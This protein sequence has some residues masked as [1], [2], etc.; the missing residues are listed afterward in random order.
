M[1]V[2]IFVCLSASPSRYLSVVSH[3]SSSTYRPM[4][5]LSTSLAAPRFLLEG[6]ILVHKASLRRH[7]D[8]DHDRVNTSSVV[9][10]RSYQSFS[11]TS[12]SFYFFSC[13]SNSTIRHNLA[14]T[15][16]GGAIYLEGGSAFSIGT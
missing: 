10:R 4:A 13:N 6:M 5:Q 11:P 9:Y 14:T 16:G 12:F 8:D 3:H 7:D 2:C 15:A 1:M